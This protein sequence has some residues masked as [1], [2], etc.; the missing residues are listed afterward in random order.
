M[1]I[2]ATLILSLLLLAGCK[3]E[4]DMSSAV[5]VQVNEAKLTAQ[6]FAE[7]LAQSLQGM[8]ALSARDESIVSEAKSRIIQ[9]FVHT[10]LI[11]TWAK[12][13]G[14][15]VRKELLQEKINAIR[16]QYPDETSFRQALANTNVRYDEWVKRLQE[17]VLEEIV[18]LKI[19]S[20]LTGINEN[21]A[22]QYYERHKANFK[23][24]AQI[25]LS[26]I[27]LKDEES[28]SK[29]YKELRNGANFEALAKK[30][31][32]TPEGENGGDLG[33]VTRGTNEIFDTTFR[34]GIKQYSKP[35]KGPFGYHI[36]RPMARQTAKTRSFNE[37]KDAIERLLLA[38]KEQAA[39]SHWLEQQL[40]K[41]RVYKNE[42]LIRSIKIATK[43]K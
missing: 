40:L 31:S 11:S 10:T 35:I 22:A 5:V 29:I 38:E 4:A 23:Q 30:Y 33:W 17:T 37:V 8:N 42:P 43:I 34:I 15:F 41:V 36:L 19:R 24:E 28:A 2:A 27:V 1:R 3:E 25:R 12:E 32:Q 20:E 14:L 6:E 13:T 9:K 26:Q 21:E 7:R 39:Y 16:A 18:S